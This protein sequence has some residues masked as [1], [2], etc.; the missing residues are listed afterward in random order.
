M[1]GERRAPGMDRPAD[2]LNLPEKELGRNEALH[3]ALDAGKE[4]SGTRWPSREVEHAEGEL[5]ERA[6]GALVHGTPCK[7]NW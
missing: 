4:H 5:G 3:A 1:Q 6:E 2:P 7:Q